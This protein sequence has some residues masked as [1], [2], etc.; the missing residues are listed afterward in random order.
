MAEDAT[1]MARRDF[2]KLEH[3]PDWKLHAGSCECKI[4]SEKA[5]A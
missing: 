1:E 5:S 2:E 4:E 3:V